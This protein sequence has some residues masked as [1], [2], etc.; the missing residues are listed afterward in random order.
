[1][2]KY[3]SYE[4]VFEKIKNTEPKLRFKHDTD[5]GEWRHQAKEK[6]NDL[7]G[8]PFELCDEQFVILQKRQRDGFEQFDFEFQSE[9]NYFVKGSFLKPDKIEVPSPTMICLQGH[10]SG[11]HIS[12][13]E[14]KFEND[15][16]TIAGGRDFAVRTVKEGLCAV[17]IE[18]RYMGVAGQNEKGSPECIVTFKAL[19]SLTLGRCAIGERVWDIQRLID[20][21]I[22]YFS[23]YVDV[24]NIICMGNSGGGTTSFYAACVDERISMVVPSCAVCTYDDSILAMSHC[25]CNYIPGIRKHFDMGDLGM[26]IAPRK[27]LLVCGKEDTIFPLEGVKK[28]FEIIKTAYVAMNKEEECKMIIGDGGHQFY[29]D[30]AWPVIHAMLKK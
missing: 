20:I 9:E 2:K 15:A 1:M 23:E 13:N 27:M 19:P 10:S 4:Y 25:A 28:S 3:N 5:F 16:K 6:I 17:V 7:L 14:A 22:K 29:P 21:L 11:M 8:L 26:L 24:D 18:Q 30:D 12:L